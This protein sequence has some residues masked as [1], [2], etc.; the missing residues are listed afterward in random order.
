MPNKALKGLDGN[1]TTSLF[2]DY[3]VGTI[4]F[5]DEYGKVEKLFL[6]LSEY[7]KFRY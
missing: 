4:I 5:F 7:Y 3:S 6:N 1:G 2:T